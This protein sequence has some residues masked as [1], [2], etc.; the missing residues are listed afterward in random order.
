MRTS[1]ELTEE[2]YLPKIADN[3]EDGEVF[4]GDAYWDIN[5]DYYQEEKHYERDYI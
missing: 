3:Y 4:W 2:D 1:I 5:E